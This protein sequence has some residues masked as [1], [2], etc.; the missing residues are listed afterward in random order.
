MTQTVSSSVH[1]YCPVNVSGQ[2]VAGD[3]AAKLVNAGKIARIDEASRE[4]GAR[5]GE[6]KK[7]ADGANIGQLIT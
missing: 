6:R 3:Y 7:R 4:A 1:T 5:Q 2:V